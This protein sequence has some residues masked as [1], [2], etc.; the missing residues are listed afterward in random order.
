MT[1]PRNSSQYRGRR[2]QLRL[3]LIR[4]EQHT[5]QRAKPQLNIAEVA[6]CGLKKNQPPTSMNPARNS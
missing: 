5:Y 3:D 1:P 4:Q 2:R 6:P